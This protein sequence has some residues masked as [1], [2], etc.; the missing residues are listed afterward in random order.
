MDE[1][2]PYARLVRFLQ[3]LWNY[4]GTLAALSL[5]AGVLAMGMVHMRRSIPNMQENTRFFRG[6]Y[7]SYDNIIP[8]G[9]DEIDRKEASSLPCCVQ[10]IYDGN[11]LQRIVTINEEGIP[12]A[13]VGCPVA[14]QRM[15]YDHDGR[16]TARKNYDSNGR[17]CADLSSVAQYLYEYD[18][19][20]HLKK[21]S[22]HD[23]NGKL[24]ENEVPGYAFEE[25]FY[26]GGGKLI[27]RVFRGAN[28]AKCL[29]RAGEQE[30]RYTYYEDGQLETKRN[31]RDGSLADNAVGVA[32]ER[33]R[34]DHRGRPK[35]MEYRNSKGEPSVC[36][37]ADTGYAAATMRYDSRGNCASIRYYDEENKISDDNGMKYAEHVRNYDGYGN[38]VYECFIDATGELCVPPAVGYAEKMCNYDT[39]NRLRREYFWDADGRP[40]SATSS[41]ERGSCYERHHEYDGNRESILSLYTDG[42]SELVMRNNVSYA[43]S[44]GNKMVRNSSKDETFE[45]NGRTAFEPGSCL[46]CANSRERSA[47]NEVSSP[48]WRAEE[49]SN[50]AWRSMNE[51]RSV[52]VGG[53][54]ISPVLK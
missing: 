4:S 33:W 13:A 39:S 17:L 29:N 9:V 24:M 12:E 42:S 34:Y 54:G 21:V 32:E 22:F 23:V 5:F 28:G 43:E 10:F 46:A 48:P 18:A 2:R 11:V 36:R 25:R 15:S 53:D 37:T 35:R 51:A 1:T 38:P 52:G 7:H 47:R 6:V 31:Y 26:D 49:T 20:G 19:Q 45:S 16:L 8:F 44:Q 41:T 50:V 30:L 40:G 3:M 14:E 27:R